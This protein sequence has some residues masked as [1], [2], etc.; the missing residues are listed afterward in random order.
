MNY[1][2]GLKA[3]QRVC[4]VTT[5]A[6]Q[7]MHCNNSACVQGS[8][9]SAS[10]QRIGSKYSIYGYD[11]IAQICWQRQKRRIN[12]RRLYESVSEQIRVCESLER[13]L[14]YQH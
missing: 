14:Y 5:I 12:F 9:S 4:E 6:Y 7:P 1:L 2:N 8:W 13:Y 10:W 3:V 11:V